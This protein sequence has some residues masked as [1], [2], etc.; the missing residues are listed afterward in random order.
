MSDRICVMQGGQILQVGSPKDLYDHPR[1]RCVA[2]F[3]GTSNFFDGKI[4]DVA[5]DRVLLVHSGGMTLQRYPVGE[6]CDGQDA[7]LSL[8]PEQIHLSRDA[9]PRGGLPVTILNKVRSIPATGR[10]RRGTPV[11]HAFRIENKPI[12]PT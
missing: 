3:V 4:T 8:R 10:R 12:G 1:N 7:C 9:N 5:G 6:F 11:P 2:G